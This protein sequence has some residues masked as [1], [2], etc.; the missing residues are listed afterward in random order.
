[1][2]KCEMCEGKGYEQ[3]QSCYDEIHSRIECSYCMG[4]GIKI[5]DDEEKKEIVNK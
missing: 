4:D 2:T 5:K 3:I 1:M